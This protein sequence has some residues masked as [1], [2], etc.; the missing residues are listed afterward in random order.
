MRK[1]E[2]FSLNNSAIEEA[3]A[4]VRRCLEECRF[5]A[6][7]SV[8]AALVTEEAIGSLVLH[9]TGTGKIRISVRVFFGTITID[10]SAPGTEYNLTEA[11]AS[12]TLPG[13]DEELGYEAQEVIGNIL[14]RTMAEDLKYRHKDGRNLIRITAVRSKKSFLYMTLGALAAAAA[15]GVLLSVFGSPSLNAGLNGF[16]FVPIKT[17]YLNAL[18]MIVAPV[19][20]FSIVTCISAFP[21]L[22]ELGHISGRIISLYVISTSIAIAIGIGVFYLIQPGQPVPAEALAAAEETTAADLSVQELLIN[23]VPSNFINPFLTDN[24]MQLIFLAVLCGIATGMI[25]SYSATLK[26]LFEALNELFLKIA[27]LIIRF[28]PLA[29]YGSL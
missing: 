17:V 4:F 19:V 23:I 29:V 2:Q 25:G 10:M 27:G 5:P 11:M 6:R 13:E 9:G 18:K 16:I 1:T 3:T 26:A 8:K 7:E 14:L 28:M 15:A 12:A 24:M 21:N 22:A 20:F